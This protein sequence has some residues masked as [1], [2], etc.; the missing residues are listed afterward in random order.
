MRISMSKSKKLLLTLFVI[1]LFLKFFGFIA[2][3]INALNYIFTSLLIFFVVKYKEPCCYRKIL[4]TYSFFIFCSCLYSFLYNG[5][6][7]FKTIFNSYNYLGLL[8]LFYIMNVKLHS[9]QLKKITLWL[10]LIFCACYIFQWIIYPITIFSGS[11]DEVNISDEA[12]R[13]RMPGSLCAYILF[14]YGL[15][16]YILTKNKKNLLYIAFGFLPILIMGFRSLIFCSI[17]FA[18]IMIPYVTKNLK[19]SFKWILLGCI[20]AV[21][22]SQLPIVQL[23]IDEMVDRQER[24]DT[25]TN[26]DYVRYLEYYYFSDY[27][28]TKEYEHMFGG[29][30]PVF[31]GKSIYAKN[32]QDATDSY[33]YYWNDLG[34]LGLSFII[35]IPAVILFIITILKSISSCKDRDLQFIRFSMLAVLCASLITSMEIYRTGNFIIIA[36]LLS[37]ECTRKKEICY[38]KNIANKTIH[39]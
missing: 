18:L 34:L 30:V 24:G 3:N 31:D 10:S 11:L 6:S 13:M 29:G 7:L 4:L 5:Q 14:F 25:F 33:L 32:I 28:F 35:G 38:E 2:L 1:L 39:V 17:L 20:I 37:I 9:S 23:K 22:A 16:N 26:K 27:I 36:L 21:I 8:F 19:K 12:F 15:N